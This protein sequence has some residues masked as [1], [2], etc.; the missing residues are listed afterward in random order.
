M[1]EDPIF[2]RRKVTSEMPQ[3]TDIVDWKETFFLNVVVQ[4]PSMLTVAVC[5]RGTGDHDGGKG[6]M[7]AIRRVMKKVYASPY[8]TRMDV[9]SSGGA[10]CSYPLIYYSIDDYDC[11]DLHL[12]IAEGEYLCVELAVIVPKSSPE[13]CDKN[14]SSDSVASQIK[15]AMETSPSTC[16]SNPSMSIGTNG[17]TNNPSS[18]IPDDSPISSAPLTSSL[19]SKQTPIESILENKNIIKVN[20]SEWSNAM[21]TESSSLNS[22]TSYTLGYPPTPPTLIQTQNQPQIQPQNQTLIR[23]IAPALNPSTPFPTPAN[24]KKIILFQGAVPFSALLDIYLQKMEANRPSML[25]KLSRPSTP[26]DDD[27]NTKSSFVMMRGPHGK[28]Q[29]QVAVL[30]VEDELSQKKEQEKDRL[31]VEAKIKENLLKTPVERKPPSFTD[32]LKQFSREV[33]NQVISV[34]T[35]T[36]SKPRMLN[37]SLTY[38]NVPWQSVVM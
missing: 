30:E 15:E 26:N 4:T 29:C 5:R 13:S 12:T 9:K 36:I 37:A 11:Q 34:T 16:D 35:S 21:G 25:D 31:A 14:T 24:T 3:L 19:P 20:Q 2:V 32:R 22:P 10:E 33:R 1:I 18:S 38:V 8:K 17:K 7:V 6:K 27:T 23:N 28:G